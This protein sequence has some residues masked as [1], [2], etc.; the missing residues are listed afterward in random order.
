MS[1]HQFLH[2]LDG[3]LQTIGLLEQHGVL[4]LQTLEYVGIVV[5]QRA[6][7]VQLQPDRPVHQHHM[8]PLDVAIGVAAIAR[9]RADAGHH[10]TNLVV[11]VQGADGDARE[12]SH[13]ADSL[14]VHGSHYRP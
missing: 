7:L 5:E 13:R 14:G 11:M 4:P 8:Q 9:R 1:V 10:E 12:S 6:D 3:V 2:C